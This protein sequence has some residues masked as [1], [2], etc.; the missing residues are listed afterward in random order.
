M[1]TQYLSNPEPGQYTGIKTERGFV[2]FNLNGGDSWGYFHPVDNPA[3]IHNFKGEPCYRTQDLLPAYWD[4]IKARVQN[5]EPDSGGNV[6]LAFRDFASA[7]YWNGIYS[8]ASDR[9]TK[10]AQAKSESQLRHFMKQHGQPIGDFIPDW[11]MRF[12]PHSKLV[13]DHKRKRLNIYQPSPYM[14]RPAVPQATVPKTIHKV[15]YHALGSNKETYERFLNWL[16]VI[17]QNLG[18][19][20]TAWVIHGTQGTGK[21]LMFHHI[22]TPLFGDENVTSR[23]MEELGSDFTEFMKNKFL[24]FIDEVFPGSDNWRNVVLFVSGTMAVHMGVLFGK[25]QRTLFAVFGLFFVYG[26]MQVGLDMLGMSYAH[27]AIVL[28]ASLFLVA[29]VCSVGYTFYRRGRCGQVEP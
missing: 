28:G 16:A 15:I 2:Y 5:L 7:T 13:V 3:F 17:V 20:Q 10:I 27:I 4:E 12:D 23:R 24:V 21:G 8:S 19:T 14:K 9:L 29:A 11:D 26:F 1:D 6:Y 25:Y 18:M 22:L